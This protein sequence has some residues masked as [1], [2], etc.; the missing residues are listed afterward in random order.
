MSG[1]EETRR[2]ARP[3][4][5]PPWRTA[6]FLTVAG[7]FNYADRSALNAVLPAVAAEMGLGSAAL[8]LL[9]SLFL[10]SYA[11]GSPFAGIAGDRFPR[12]TLVTISLVAWSVV[13]ILTGCAR[14]YA[15]LAVLRVA[16][17]LAEC[18]YIPTAVAL[19]AEQHGPATRGRAVGLAM[20]GIQVGST[21]GGTLSGLLADHH[22]W[23]TGFW[24]LGAGGL[25]LALFARPMLGPAPGT[26]P[27]GPG[28]SGSWREPFA[29]LLRSPLYLL[30]LAATGLGSIGLWAMATWLPLFL[31]E[32]Y[33]M[34]LG[35]SG[36]YGTFTLALSVILGAVAGG[37]LSDR[38]ARGHVGRRL[39]LMAASSLISAPAAVIFLLGLPFPWLFA[40]MV[41]TGFVGSVG[42][43]NLI[44]LMCDAVPP[45]GHATAQGVMNT[46]SVIAGGAGVVLAGIL[47]P[48]VGLDV[49][50]A[51]RG[52][53]ALLVA[54][55]YLYAYLAWHRH[56]SARTTG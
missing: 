28:R 39:L 3:W 23:R 30:L 36:F 25:L 2:S 22:S 48:S 44:P 55:L 41:L 54:G 42:G 56:Q 50:F 38:F 10:W 14:T 6:L 26:T 21:V 24:I 18:L 40:A 20:I 52:G 13:T 4:L 45:A 49:L 51:A 27:G 37:W 33:D 29:V 35:A 17:G 32:E 11:V 46:L 15:E 53:I 31:K 8:G 12:R 1:P 5:T 43:T 47:K 9:G 7:G 16:L 34:S 19:L